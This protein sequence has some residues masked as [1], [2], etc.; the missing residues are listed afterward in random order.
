MWVR[1]QNKIKDLGDGRNLKI[2]NA[3]KNKIKLIYFIGYQLLV[4]FVCN[5]TGNLN[6]G[7]IYSELYLHKPKWLLFVQ[8]SAQ[9]QRHFPAMF[10]QISVG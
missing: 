9:L 1:G 5:L 4:W 6:K 7:F 2:I 10:F 8:V 3:K